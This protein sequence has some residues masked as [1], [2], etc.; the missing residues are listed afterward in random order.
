MACAFSNRIFSWSRLWIVSLVGHIVFLQLQGLFDDSG[1]KDQLSLE[2]TIVCL[3]SQ[4]TQN[5]PV[6]YLLH[7]LCHVE[8]ATDSILCD[9][10]NIYKFK[11]IPLKRHVQNLLVNKNKYDFL[12]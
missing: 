4:N 6:Y 12:Y 2:Y 11:D 7:T 3:H 1:Q 8:S 5:T 10:N 9:P